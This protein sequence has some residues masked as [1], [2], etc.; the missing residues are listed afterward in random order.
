MMRK[1][2]FHREAAEPKPIGNLI[3]CYDCGG[4]GYIV[5]SGG[6]VILPPGWRMAWKWW[7]PLYI[8]GECAGKRRALFEQ[9]R[10]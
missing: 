5:L 1:R 3:R 8:C 10:K 2:L 6:E 4:F 9:R 7:K